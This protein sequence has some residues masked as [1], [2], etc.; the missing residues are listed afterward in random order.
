MGMV[1]RLNSLSENL[2]V[3]SSLTEK[4]VNFFGCIQRTLKSFSGYMC[5]F[6]VYYGILIDDTLHIPRR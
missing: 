4:G 5:R 1:V 6:S 3:C 2:A